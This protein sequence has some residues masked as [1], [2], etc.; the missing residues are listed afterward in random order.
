MNIGAFGDKPFIVSPDRIYTPDGVS[1]TSGLNVEKQ[2]VEGGKPATYIKGVK[3]KTVTFDLLLLVA[4]CDVDAE[5]EWWHIEAESKS[6]KYLTLGIK[7][8]GKMLLESVSET[9]VLI[10]P[11]GIKTR[12]KLSL[13][14]SEWTKAGYKKDKK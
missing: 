8:Y 3:E 9:D 7:T 5:A 10:A 12:S 4:F 1:I 2:E 13:T 11:N 14:F 6:A